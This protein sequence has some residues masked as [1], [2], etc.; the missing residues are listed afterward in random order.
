MDSSVNTIKKEND[1]YRAQFL[2][3]HRSHLKGDH[4][5]TFIV[6]EGT[7]LLKFAKAAKAV[8]ESLGDYPS[9][10]TGFIRIPGGNAFATFKY[11]GALA[12]STDSGSPIKQ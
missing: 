9:S 1:Y 7:D 12:F 4:S 11:E 10:F 3:S 5:M 8:W 2:D 6:K